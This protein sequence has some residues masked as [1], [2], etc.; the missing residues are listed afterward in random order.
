MLTGHHA[1]VRAYDAHASS[2]SSTGFRGRLRLSVATTERQC[3]MIIAHLSDLH[4]RETGKPFASGNVDCT[5]R[6]AQAF[7]RVANMTPRP[8]MMVVTGDLADSG[9][10]GEYQLLK[11][12]T[13]GL[14]F[15]V[16]L[17][18]GNHDIRENFLAV[19]PEKKGPGGFVQFCVEHD[20][21]R[22]IGLD[23]LVEGEGLGRLC[24]ERL[25]YLRD[26]LQE[27]PNTSTLILLHHPP[28]AFGGG[29]Y[30]AVR[31]I[32]GAR[33]LGEII[34]ANKQVVRLL[35]GHHHRA[36]DCL[37]NGT[38]ASVAPSVV[39]SCHLQL[40]DVRVF[41]NINEPPA[42]KLH[43]LVP[44]SGFVS[45]N[46]FVEDFGPAYENIP[47]PNYQALASM[48]KQTALAASR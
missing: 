1:P 2:N 43:V 25:S 20:K 45:H 6:A 38:L 27:R 35:C 36:I 40:G 32:D 24:S 28:F 22:V 29:I 10:I 21:L 11:E 12:L 44:E 47:D 46:V 4:I 3:S 23:T 16:H 19:F 48:R 41:K 15:P 5:A 34:T 9:Q 26:C 13:E 14:P 18:L 7:E 39:S 30:D 42:F 31:L 8:D 17:A 33:E 37:W